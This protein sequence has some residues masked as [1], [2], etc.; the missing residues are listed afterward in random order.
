MIPSIVLMS[1]LA[2]TAMGANTNYTYTFP[3][4]FNIGLVDPGDLCRSTTSRSRRNPLTQDQQQ[5]LGA[6]DRPMCVP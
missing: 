5:L 2:A 3:A 6:W 1:A 4:G